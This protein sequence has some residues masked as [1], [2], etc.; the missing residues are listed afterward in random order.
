M[1]IQTV[2]NIILGVGAFVFTAALSI[3]TYFIKSVMDEFREL[4]DHVERGKLD[5]AALD[6]DL[7]SIKRDVH[8]LQVRQDRADDR[9]LA[10]Q[11]DTSAILAILADLP[12]LRKDIAEVRERIARLEGED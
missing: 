7:S 6:K 2:I 5:V 4:K 1:D 11:R 3:I 8:T 12:D 9:L 10:I